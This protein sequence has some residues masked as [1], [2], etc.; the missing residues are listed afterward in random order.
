MSD[1]RIEE[2]GA[3]LE[4]INDQK[5]RRLLFS[6]VEMLAGSVKLALSYKC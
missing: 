5:V 2:K 6:N 4:L 1:G 3:Y